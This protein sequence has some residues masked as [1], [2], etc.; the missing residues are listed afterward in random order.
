MTHSLRGGQRPERNPL[1]FIFCAFLVFSLVP[2]MIGIAPLPGSLARVPTPFGQLSAGLIVLGSVGV[3]VGIL[4]VERDLG[5]LIQQAS[6]WFLAVGLTFYGVAVWHASG[7]AA[8]RIA[9]GL[10]L[11]FA[12]GCVARVVQFQIY[13][14]HR[15]LDTADDKAAP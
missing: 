10:S 12:A 8:G 1:E 15:A 14:Y 7:W 2:V 9:V 3:M 4:W 5:L 13:V 6:M 11:G